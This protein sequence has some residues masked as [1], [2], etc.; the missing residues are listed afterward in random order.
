[1][2][3]QIRFGVNYTPSKNWMFFLQDFNEETVRRDL[4]NIHNLGMDHLRVCVVWSLI[5]PAPYYISEHIMGNLE[6]LMQIAEENQL[7]VIVSVLCGWISGY[8]FLPA[9]RTDK[10]VFTHEGMIDTEKFLM[11]AVAK[12]IGKYENLLGIDLGNE[13]NVVEEGEFTSMPASWV[14]KE[15]GNRWLKEMTEFVKPLI[16]GKICSLGVDHQPWMKDF[17][18]DREVLANISDPVPLHVYAKF[19]G[20]M[21]R[22]GSMS[23]AALH[24]MEYNIEFARA[25]MEEP[26]HKI[27][28]QE[29]GACLDWF[30]S[31]EEQCQFMTES[32]KHVV[33]S[34]NVWGITLWSSHGVP[35]FMMK[36]IASNM[37]DAMVM[38]QGLALFDED[39]Q[40]K[41]LA[42]AV[43]K[44]IEEYRNGAYPVKKKTSAYIIEDDTYEEIIRRNIEARRVEGGAENIYT[45]TPGL[46]LYMDYLSHVEGEEYPGIVLRRNAENEMYL[47]RRGINKLIR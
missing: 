13:L 22:C 35:E 31:V 23:N 7:S 40:P 1:M 43:K 32:M 5:Q 8:T 26:E 19:Q 17:M 38:E 21:D 3:N 36:A 30:D 12:R 20:I 42:F 24:A 45:F 9:F 33:Q 10:N 2:R 46:E 34:E 37:A 27:W 25:F 16:P 4:E 18:F 41:P 29:T 44:F 28:I 14:T 15:E 11:E 47:N 39:N 6:R